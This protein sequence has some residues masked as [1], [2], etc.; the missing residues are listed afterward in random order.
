MSN[1]SE[2]NQK[3]HTDAAI[4]TLHL[5]DSGR[6]IS[7]VSTVQFKDGSVREYQILKHQGAVAIVAHDHQF[8][9]L[10]KQFRFAVNKIILE[11]P[12]GLIDPN[13][14]KENAAIRECQEE[15][16][17]LPQNLQFL[18]TIYT[19]PGILNEKIHLFLATDFKPSYIEADDSFEID[20]VKIP[21]LVA[22]SREFIDTLEDAKTII[23]LNLL[24][25]HVQSII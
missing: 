12:A 1:Q 20:I 13:E 19:S 15:V 22:I 16:H 2:E 5:F 17:L 4:S 24:K 6:I 11:L 7:A 18:K 23:G 14:T 8:V 21:I 9:Y 10:V 3:H 25:N